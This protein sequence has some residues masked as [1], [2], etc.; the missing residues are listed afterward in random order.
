MG[1]RI[2][3]PWGFEDILEVNDHYVVKRLM[4]KQGARCSFQYHENK[5]E[6]I[7]VLSGTLRLHVQDEDSDL[8]AVI[9]MR[10]GDH[11]TITPGIAHRMEGGTDCLYLESST[12][13]L[14]DVVRLE[15]DYGRE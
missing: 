14:D 1:E 15:D 3:K 13:E 12:T 9:E 5:T 4:M 11:Y 7:Y 6:T 8:V 2:D 10:E